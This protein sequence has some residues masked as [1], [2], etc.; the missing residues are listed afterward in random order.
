LGKSI[1]DVNDLLTRLAKLEQL[2][3]DFHAY[4]DAE[5]H[6]QHELSRGRLQRKAA[7]IRRDPAKHDLRKD[8]LKVPL[9]PYQLDG[10]AFAAHAGRAVWRR[11]AGSA[12]KFLGEL[13][14]SQADKPA[15]PAVVTDLRNRLAEC[16]E[17]DG[18]GR[19]RLTV[20]LPDRA[21]LNQLADALAQ[22][23][24]VGK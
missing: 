20:K 18:N 13:V 21:A 16:V 2:G 8:L 7:E 5:E 14:A 6:I 17:E 22:L 11:N 10:I 4:P 15:E 24:A 12:F 19:P 9:L 3:Q 23:L 1:T